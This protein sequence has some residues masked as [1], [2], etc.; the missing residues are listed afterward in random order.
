[1]RQRGGYMDKALY[2]NGSGYKDKTAGQALEKVVIK[3]REKEID[4]IA[5]KMLQIIK[6]VLE[7]W[8]FELVECVQIKHTK[9]G[10]TYK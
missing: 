4:D 10:R 7:I 3:E 9:T 8:G 6:M 5:G 2:R 1:M